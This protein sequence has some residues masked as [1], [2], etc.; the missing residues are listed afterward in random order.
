[1]HIEFDTWEVI[2]IILFYFLIVYTLKGLFIVFV[3]ILI[4]NLINNL[5]EKGEQIREQFQSDGK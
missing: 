3:V 4:K 5:K 2:T 1:M